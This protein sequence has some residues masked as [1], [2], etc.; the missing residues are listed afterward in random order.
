MLFV[1]KY[2]FGLA[3]LLSVCAFMFYLFKIVFSRGMLFVSGSR[4]LCTGPTTSLTN[5]IFTEICL[6]VGSCTVHGTIHTFKNY[7][8]TIFSIF[9]KISGIQMDPKYLHSA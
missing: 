3:F 1:I 4:V 5:K 9:S 7:F 2:A 6:L 8:A